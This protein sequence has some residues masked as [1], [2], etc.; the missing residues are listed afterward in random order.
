MRTILEDSALVLD[1]AKQSSLVVADLH[2]GFS[3]EIRAAKGVAI[4][5]E[6]DAMRARLE[7]LIRK[8]HPAALYIVGDLKHTLSADS[9]FN[10]KTIPDF[11]GSIS[12]LLPV[13]LIPGN[14]DG[15][16]EALL[17]R[18]V[19]ITDVRGKI[20]DAEDFPVGLLH[21]HTWPSE[22]VLSAGLVIM[23]HQHPSIRRTRSVP[24]PVA[25]AIGVKRSLGTFPVVMKSSLDTGCVRR[26]LRL[27]AN[28]HTGK[29]ELVIL[30]SFNPLI[31]GIALNDRD[32]VLDGPLFER[33][34]I[35]LPASEVFS[36]DGVLLGTVGDLQQ[37]Q[38]N[39]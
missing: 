14:H 13:T 16:L 35:D 6:Q 18:S 21:G 28:H 15:D 36:V 9:A 17:P 34:C 1:D 33:G 12:S 4:P 38:R 26:S 19:A 25:G 3:A 2:L 27:P 39:D 7:S 24:S 20:I 37:I 31:S 10:W 23:G 11:V 29:V 30:P 5:E 8:H 32:V 22:E